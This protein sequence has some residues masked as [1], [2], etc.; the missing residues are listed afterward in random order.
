MSSQGSAPAGHGRRHSLGIKKRLAQSLRQCGYEVDDSA[1]PLQFQSHC[2][3]M[4]APAFALAAL[5]VRNVAVAATEVEPRAAL[6]HLFNHPLT[7]HFDHGHEIHGTG[8]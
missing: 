8:R 4:D 1:D 2:A 3:G 6:F 5:G 7:E